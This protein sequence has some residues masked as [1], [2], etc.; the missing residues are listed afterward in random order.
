MTDLTAR[1]RSTLPAAVVPPT[2][3]T[4]E[5]GYAVHDTSVGRMLL[6]CNDSGVLVASLFTPDAAAEDAALVRLAARV[7]PAR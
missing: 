1:L 6:A 7:S 2:F 3:P 4:P 5:I